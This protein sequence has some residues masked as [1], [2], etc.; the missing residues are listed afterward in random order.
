[1]NEIRT[2]SLETTYAYVEPTGWGFLCPSSTHLAFLVKSIFRS[3]TKCPVTLLHLG[4]VPSGLLRILRRLRQFPSSPWQARLAILE[5]CYFLYRDY[6]AFILASTFFST[7]AAMALSVDL[8][9]GLPLFFFGFFPSDFWGFRHSRSSSFSSLERRLYSG[10]LWYR[11]CT[12]VFGQMP[13][14]VPKDATSA[15]SAS[16]CTSEISAGPRLVPAVL[17]LATGQYGTICA[18]QASKLL[19]MPSGALSVRTAAIAACNGV[20]V[21]D[22]CQQVSNSTVLVGQLVVNML[23]T[24]IHRYISIVMLC[25]M[26]LKWEIALPFPPPGV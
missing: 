11:R 25:A 10:P 1:V 2:L 7:V 14:F 16:A 4:E 20:I 6:S 22:A 17:F 15:S 26:F 18:T 13:D 24:L 9:T 19:C 8:Y 21:F 12:P 3:Q 23:C 5:S